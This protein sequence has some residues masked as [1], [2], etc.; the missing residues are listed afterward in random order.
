MLKTCSC[1]CGLTFNA[2]VANGHS[3]STPAH[4]MP[5]PGIPL[6]IHWALQGYVGGS[7]ALPVLPLLSLA[8][9]QTLVAVHGVAAA[10]VQQPV[11]TRQNDLV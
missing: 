9:R 11:S 7:Q 8:A 5:G 6:S 4:P 10:S 1:V 3:T 2:A